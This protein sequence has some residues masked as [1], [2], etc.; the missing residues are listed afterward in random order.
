MERPWHLYLMAIVYILAGLNHFRQPELY[1]KIIPSFLP[2]KTFIIEIT[3]FLTI[4]FG[5][6]LFIPKLIPYALWSIIALLI[7]VLPANINM[8]VNKEARLGIP[9]WILSLRIPIQF[10]LMYWAYQYTF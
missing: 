10:A 2:K 5:C 7:A 8:L 4:M 9:V 1:K 3:G 6:Y